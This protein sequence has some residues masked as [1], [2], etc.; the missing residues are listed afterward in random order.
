[1]Q[2][3]CRPVAPEWER[4]EVRGSESL[5]GREAQRPIRPMSFLA[6]HYVCLIFPVRTSD[7]RVGGSTPFGRASSAFLR[8]AL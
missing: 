6:S 5:S 2:T 1:M 3:K 4:F 8:L 7:P